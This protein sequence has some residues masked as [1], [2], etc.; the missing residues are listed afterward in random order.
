MQRIN[1]EIFIQ[2][3]IEQ[4]WNV[5]SDLKSYHEWNSQIH[6]KSGAISLGEHL[7]IRL[8]PLYYRSRST[9]AVI[10]DMK[11]YTRFGL[12]GLSLI[13]YLLKVEYLF[14]LTDLEEQKVGLHLHQRY[15]GPLAFLMNK[16]SRTIDARKSCMKMNAEIRRRVE[17]LYTPTE[18]LA[19]LSA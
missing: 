5:V 12:S 10:H 14:T 8:N 18:E 4:V 2:G 3:S 13:P 15:Y 19:S 11:P 1:S 6:L 7:K 17:E 9:S 16:R